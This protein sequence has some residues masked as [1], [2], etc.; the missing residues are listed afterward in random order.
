LQDS[1][2]SSTKG[3]ARLVDPAAWHRESEFQRPSKVQ[4]KKADLPERA[5]WIEDPHTDARGRCCVPGHRIAIPRP[6]TEG[7][8]KDGATMT[9]AFFHVV[10]K[11]M[12]MSNGDHC[13]VVETALRDLWFAVGDLVQ[14]NF[15]YGPRSGTIC[16]F[17]SVFAFV[18]FHDQPYKSA[19][20]RPE[21]VTISLLH[22]IERDPAGATSAKDASETARRA[23]PPPPP[24]SESPGASSKVASETALRSPPPPSASPGDSSMAAYP[25]SASRPL[26]HASSS[27][28]CSSSSSGSNSSSPG[29][30]SSGSHSSVGT[31]CS[32]STSASSSKSPEALGGDCAG[33]NDGKA[34]ESERRHAAR[35]G[36]SQ[37]SREHDKQIA[38]LISGVV[39]KLTRCECSE[40]LAFVATMTRLGDQC[41]P[42]NINTGLDLVKRFVHRMGPWSRSANS[43]TPTSAIA[44]RPAQHGLGRIVRALKL[45]RDFY[46]CFGEELPSGPRSGA[47]NAALQSA[48]SPI[49]RF[50][51]DPETTPPS[52]KKIR[53]T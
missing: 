19:C 2:A 22:K 29:S 3:K 42:T 27:A 44:F 24:P 45:L 10:I 28:C 23:P 26:V 17:K 48:A 34:T 37:T 25:V 53:L 11:D 8:S 1:A 6:G 9:R 16:S 49:S 41:A 43:G 13:T 14:V 21:T 35:R 50:A 7:D 36:H 51:P 33:K 18:A 32:S 52:A 39:R 40:A 47:P 5:P 12:A 20:L 30:D 46:D 38:E 4:G 15:A 31:S